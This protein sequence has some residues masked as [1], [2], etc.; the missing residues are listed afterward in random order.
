MKNFESC[1]VYIR[2]E[3]DEDIIDPVEIT[4]PKPHFIKKKYWH[5]DYG[6]EI[7]LYNKIASELLS[8]SEKIYKNANEGITPPYPICESWT[9]WFSADKLRIPPENY[10]RSMDRFNFI[11][12]INQVFPSFSDSNKENDK[13]KKS[14][15]ELL[16][17]HFQMLDWFMYIQHRVNI[18][19]GIKMLVNKYEFINIS[20]IIEA[21]I[22]EAVSN[23]YNYCITCDNG[24]P[25]KNRDFCKNYL[26]DGKD[27]RM[28]IQ[29][30]LKALEKNDTLGIKEDK[31]ARKKYDPDDTGKID[32]Y[33]ELKE[34]FKI[35]NEV[36]I[37]NSID[38]KTD[39]SDN[40]GI[41]Q[42]DPYSRGM[43]YL[44]VIRDACIKNMVPYYTSCRG[45]ERKE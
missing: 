38:K 23:V 10:I 19:G 4:D 18:Y 24:E 28:P 41:D 12:E 42:N 30:A 15:N 35:R 9:P 5:P 34:L 26:S 13:E 29:K 11:Y 1:K 6:T 45:Y 8:R 32:P 40:T 7:V 43:I 2:N 39:D 22:Q 17:W 36:H 27:K 25:C 20:A 44:Y 3:K 16:A 31:R 21:Y 14:Y 37:R 33:E